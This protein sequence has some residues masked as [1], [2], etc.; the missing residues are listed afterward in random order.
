MLDINLLISKCKKYLSNGFK[1]ELRVSRKP[2][3]KKSIF[4]YNE[5]AK[6]ND[7]EG[8]V[9]FVPSTRWLL[10]FMPGNGLSLRRKT[11]VAEK[12]PSRLIDKL[13]SSI[14]HIRLSAA[15]YNYSPVNIIAMDD[16][17]VWSDM[18]S[19]T[20]VDKTG[21]RTVTMKPTGNEKCQQKR[22]E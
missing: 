10:K 16:T 13:V 17:F 2:I 22:M 7:C 3:I 9:T 12:D 21:A 14:L 19:D 5:K 20:T 15:K 18:V 6:E 8:S 4:I 1:K 11:S